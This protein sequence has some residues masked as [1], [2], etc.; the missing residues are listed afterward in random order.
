M[1]D[2]R[3]L[4]LAGPGPR[5]FFEV[6]ERLMVIGGRPSLRAACKGGADARQNSTCGKDH[7]WNAWSAPQCPSSSGDLRFAACLRNRRAGVDAEDALQFLRAGE[8]LRRLVSTR[9]AREGRGRQS[10]RDDGDGRRE[11]PGR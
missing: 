6:P 7:D 3:T 9:R 4:N 10:L 11:R 8:L 1:K 5:E 2:S